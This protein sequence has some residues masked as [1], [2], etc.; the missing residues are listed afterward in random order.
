[1]DLRVQPSNETL[2]FSFVTETSAAPAGLHAGS[3]FKFQFSSR[4]H[5]DVFE[6]DWDHQQRMNWEASNRHHVSQC[7]KKQIFLYCAMN[8]VLNVEG[9][10]LKCLISS[11]QV[12]S[13]CPLKPASVSSSW[14]VC[15]ISLY[16]LLCVF[17]C[18]AL[19]LW[20]HSAP[21]RSTECFLQIQQRSRKWAVC[22]HEDETSS[23][24]LFVCLFVCL[25]F[26]PVVPW[27]KFLCELCV[28][29]CGWY[30]WTDIWKTFYAI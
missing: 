19:P 24:C 10:G 28:Q 17:N 25:L 30:L 20:C 22:F 11:S 7:I 18:V 3:D 16:V 26:W 4:F 12:D 27:I 9:V 29:V 14:A 2:L 5:S 1:M 15:K 23:V 8:F 21:L 13:I 6:E